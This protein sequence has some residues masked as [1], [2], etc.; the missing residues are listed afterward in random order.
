MKTWHAVFPILVLIVPGAETAL[1]QDAKKEVSYPIGNLTFISPMTVA[2]VDPGGEITLVPDGT[3]QTSFLTE[4]LYLLLPMTPE[5]K[6]V[7]R[8]QV[9]EIEPKA[10]IKVKVAPESSG[11]FR[12]GMKLTLFRP[13]GASSK[14]LRAIPEVVPIAAPAD[15]SDT[16]QASREATGRAKS[17]NNL[18]Q[19]GLALHN[20][21]AANESF[22]PAVIYGP[23]GKPWHSWRVILLPYLEENELFNRYDFSQP[24]DS[25]KNRKVL[26]AIPAVYRDPNV[27]DA[28]GNFTEYA[29][30]VGK[31]TAFPPEGTRMKTPRLE[32]FTGDRKGVRSFAQVID[33]LS[34]TACVAPVPHDR[35]IPWTKPEDITFDA[36]FPELG[37][38]GGIAVP[39]H[40][41][42][43]A[44]GLGLVPV[45]LMDGSVQTLPA[46][47]KPTVLNALMTCNG[48]EII[49]PDTFQ[50]PG[51]SPPRIKTLIFKFEAGKVTATIR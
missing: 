8:V 45:L 23:D 7:F 4:G 33:G 48:G 10:H 12:K 21:N 2:E 28:K 16:V 32:S 42:G 26:E 46:T 40:L 29:A 35:K 43:K 11:S 39:Y 5:S 27:A 31:N 1:A 49:P 17:I 38:P 36:R 41:N 44:D 19:I 14:E 15:G 30:I 24:W 3:D 9:T 47:V 50:G 37:K 6:Q 13:I 22:P 25:E 34:Y 18:K 20:F 51:T